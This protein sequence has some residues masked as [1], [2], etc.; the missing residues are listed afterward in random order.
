MHKKLLL[1]IALGAV[2]ACGQKGP[3]LLPSGEPPTPTEASQ[4][5]QPT[6]EEAKKKTSSDGG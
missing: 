6:E 5:Q 3:L 4:I 1:L 2:S